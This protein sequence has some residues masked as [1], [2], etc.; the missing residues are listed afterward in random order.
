MG[1]VRQVIVQA[2]DLVLEASVLSSKLLGF[3]LVELDAKLK[4]MSRGFS[5]VLCFGGIDKLLADAFEFAAKMREG[6]KYCYVSAST[7]P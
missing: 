6:K 5:I 1:T 7:Q 4:A 2:F 3:L